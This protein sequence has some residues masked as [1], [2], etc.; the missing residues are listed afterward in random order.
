VS[1]LGPRGGVLASAVLLESDAKRLAGRLSRL[2]SWIAS[3]RRPGPSPA[4]EE[5]GLLDRDLF[6][7][8]E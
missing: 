3:S 8:E 5:P 1:I 4:G 2:A 6:G 7:W